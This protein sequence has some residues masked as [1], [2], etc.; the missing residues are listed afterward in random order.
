MA[1]VYGEERV[2]YYTND[3]QY[4]AQVAV[5]A[6]GGYVVSWVSRGQD[7]S[8]DGI[9]AQRYNSVGM[10]VGAEFRVNSA[11]AN[12]QIQPTIV[13][14]S[15]GGFVV[16]WSDQ[17]AD[18]SSWGV[19]AQ[20]YDAHGVARGSQFLVNQTTLYDQ[21]T[22]AIAAVDGGFVVT[23]ASQYQDDGGSYGVYARR[24]AN[25]G[26]PSGAEFAVNSTVS[27]NQNEPAIAAFDGGGFVVV[28]RSE[29]QDGS[30]GGV[31][32]QR[33]DAAGAA[34]GGEFRVNTT[35]DFSQADPHVAVLADG[36]FVVVWADDGSHDGSG[37]AVYA[38]RF[39]AGGTRL[40]GEFL[41]NSVTLGSQYQPAVTALASGGFVVS[42]YN[43]YYDASGSGSAAD[44]YVREY[45]ADGSPVGAEVKVNS[46]SGSYYQYEP[47]IAHLGSDNFVVVW[48]SDGQD[49]SNAGIYQQLFGSAAE[50]VRG[51]AA[52]V[53]ADFG[54]TVSF[55]ENVV[56]ATPQVLD[57]LVSFSARAGASFE[58]GVVTVF[59]VS[60]ASPADQ[61]SVRGTG[62]GVGEIGVAGSEVRYGGV[63]IG[64]VSGGTA[65]SALQIRLNAAAGADA[66][67]QGL[68]GRAGQ[69]ARRTAAD[70][71]GAYFPSLGILRIGPQI[72]QQML[73]VVIVRHF[74]FQRVRVEIAVRAFLHAPRDVNI[75][76]QRWQI[77]HYAVLPV[78]VSA[79]VHG[80]KSRF[81]LRGS[82]PQ[83]FCPRSGQRKSGRS[84][85]RRCQP[86]H[87]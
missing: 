48:R 10:P 52:P 50:L 19:F 24:Y 25:D 86:L 70:K 68:H 20:R 72:V 16:A 22:P 8:D 69:Q 33:F 84:Q 63:V 75:K 37:Y 31:Y 18:G 58:G 80:G 29:G 41:V 53:L 56:N 32:A 44:V 73:D 35:T 5:L 26:S 79:R 38:Q 87:G 49:G 30:G 82:V 13:G 54:G 61:L 17:Y 78:T 34:L 67:E 21:G 3:H 7:G 4:G 64:E 28:W 66:I 57:P 46:P 60:G 43:D 55:D 76:T 59:Y 65:G 85:S 51:N 77:S 39:D 47:A 27:G 11:T 36:S 83:R 71:N 81:S 40:G 15:D 2:N 42:W 12:A 62:D 1:A 45:A 74:A 23:W 9:Y 14:L 6:G